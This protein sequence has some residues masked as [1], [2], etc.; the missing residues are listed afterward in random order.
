MPG[1]CPWNHGV[2]DELR[3]RQRAAAASKPVFL[4]NSRRGVPGPKEGVVSAFIRLNDLIF[5]H[6]DFKSPAENF[7]PIRRF[8]AGR[9]TETSFRYKICK[10]DFRARIWSSSPQW[11]VSPKLT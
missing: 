3:L 2:S 9:P 6:I 1:P 11:R 10:L 7:A 4:R 8:E 5:K